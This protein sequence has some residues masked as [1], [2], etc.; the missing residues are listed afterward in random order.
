MSLPQW[1]AYGKKILDTI[2]YNRRGLR[3]P[4][5]LSVECKHNDLVDLSNAQA[6]WDV[7]GTRIL[8]YTVDVTNSRLSQH[9]TL[10]AADTGSLKL[11]LQA[12]ISGWDSKVDAILEAERIR[13]EKASAESLASDAEGL[14]QSFGRILRQTL[15][16]DDRVVWDQLKSKEKYKKD[17]FL[18]PRPA[19]PIAAAQPAQPILEK[20]GFFAGL[21]GGH[22]AAAKRHQDRMSVF[23][24]DVARLMVKAEAEKARFTREMEI[25]RAQAATWDAE[26]AAKAA[27]H[28]EVIKDQ[29]L[30]VDKLKDAWIAGDSAAILEHASLVLDASNYGGLFSTNYELDWIEPSRTLLVSYRL[31]TPDAVP[32]LKSAKL[33]AS[34]GEVKETFITDRQQTEIYDDA[35]YQICLRTVHELFEADEPEHL[36]AI[37]FNGLV[38]YVDRATGK[39]VIATILSMAAQRDVFLGID[40]ARVDPKVCFKSFKGVAAASLASM[41]AV[42]PVL[43]LNRSDKRFVDS[44]EISLEDQ[45]GEN[46]AAMPWEDF[47]HLIRQVF[48]QVFSA[49][50]GEVKVTQASRDGGVDAVAFDPDPIGGGKIVIQAKRYTRTVGVSAVRDLYGT[51]MNEGANKGILVT[52]ADYGPDAYAF[53][54]GKPLTLLSGSNLLHLL[55]QHGV[56]ARIDLAEARRT[57]TVL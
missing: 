29:H 20:I 38:E 50:G 23:M 27:A 2:G 31:P 3:N 10:S 30:G 15:E 14:R 33:V 7:R 39:E 18:T 52:T 51:V 53:A 13:G 47:E 46:L 45:E 42:P 57:Q 5:Y 26:Q 56:H 9:R 36:Q 11:K 54:A 48:G 12:L 22:T 32:K 19:Q 37:V 44:R 55:G 41:A 49:R 17:D 16:R 40:L 34:T 25:Y 4:M 1:V 21:F 8:R 43:Q 35:C 6:V 24:A 28:A